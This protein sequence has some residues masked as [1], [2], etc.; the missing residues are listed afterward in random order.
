MFVVKP[1]SKLVDPEWVNPRTGERF[2]PKDPKNPIG[3][4]WIG[5]IGD[6]DNIRGLEG[7]G[8]HGTI[9]PDSIGAMKSMGCVRLANDDIALVYELLMD[10]VSTVEIH[11]E[12]YP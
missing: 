11:G 10:G 6:S 1:N 8:V 3:D 7:Y 2:G 5:L 4:Y 12:D 9:D